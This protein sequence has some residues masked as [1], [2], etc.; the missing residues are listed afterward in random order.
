MAPVTAR[1]RLERHGRGPRH[2]I[3]RRLAAARASDVAAMTR[4]VRAWIGRL[5]LAAVAVAALALLFH[6]ECG[7]GGGMPGWYRDCECR[8]IER[9]DYD[10]TE[11]D[12][13][14]RTTCLG[15]VSART[16]HLYIDGPQ[17]P[18]DSLPPR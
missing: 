9:L 1:T 10:Q 2:P 18:C 11:A 8:G 15:L 12:G 6:R 13:R 17:T 14:R 5:A 7:Y 4:A 16:C 3:P